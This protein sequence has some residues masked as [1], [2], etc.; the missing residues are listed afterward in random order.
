M[1]DDRMLFLNINAD[2]GAT[3]KLKSFANGILRNEFNPGVANRGGSA[4]TQRYFK[5]YEEKCPSCKI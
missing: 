3:S 1:L 4:K 2:Q 5:L